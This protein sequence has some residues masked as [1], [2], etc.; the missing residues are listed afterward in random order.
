MSIQAQ[1]K[2]FRPEQRYLTDIE[3]DEIVRQT[4][5][6]IEARMDATHVNPTYAAAFKIVKKIARGMKP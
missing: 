2:P 1:H 4:L 5:K 6:E 3:R